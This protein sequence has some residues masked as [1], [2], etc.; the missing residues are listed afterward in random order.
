MLPPI[1]SHVRTEQKHEVMVIYSLAFLPS[2]KVSLQTPL[3]T[4]RR[5]IQITNALK[6]PLIRVF[7]FSI[8]ILYSFLQSFL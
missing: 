4:L 7:Q 3:S 2:H 5:T 6:E 1:L 8:I